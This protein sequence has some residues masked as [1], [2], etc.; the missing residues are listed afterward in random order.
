M[1]SLG[2]VQPSVVT[3]V[4]STTWSGFTPGAAAYSTSGFVN[5]GTYTVVTQAATVNATTTSSAGIATIASSA[6]SQ[7]SSST[8][9]SSA[10]PGSTSQASGSSTSSASASAASASHTGS[11]IIVT[12]HLGSLMLSLGLL[13]G[14]IAT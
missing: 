13:V 4:N 9:T 10:A 7:T 6:A 1:I 3:V 8:A 5:N 11:A 12:P 14:L 2:S